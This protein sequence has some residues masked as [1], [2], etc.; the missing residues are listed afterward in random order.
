MQAARN[1][2]GLR[3]T[4]LAAILLFAQAA[5]LVHEFNHAR[6]SHGTACAVCP[7]GNN[8]QSV[9]T[10]QDQPISVEVAIAPAFHVLRNLHSIRADSNLHARAPP[11]LV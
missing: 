10:A 6:A 11:I 5:S 3:L 1:S 9:A 7:M 4:L 8:L 2:S